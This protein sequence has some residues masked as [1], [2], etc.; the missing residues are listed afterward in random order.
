MYQNIRK[1]R[2][3]LNEQKTLLQSHNQFYSLN[4]FN[5]MTVAA[6]NE[7]LA[8]TSFGQKVQKLFVDE[9][10]S[11]VKAATDGDLIDHI[12]NKKRIKE[13]MGFGGAEYQKF[14][15][16]MLQDEMNKIY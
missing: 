10:Q 1:A 8:K 13:G 11:T 7:E 12:V 3:Q 15:M 5:E 2:I 9:L 14:N 6:N 16:S 4:N